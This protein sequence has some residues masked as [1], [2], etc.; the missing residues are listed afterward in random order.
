M[1]SKVMCVEMEKS[2]DIVRERDAIKQALSASVSDTASKVFVAAFYKNAYKMLSADTI[3]A[4]ISCRTLMI[5]NNNFLYNALDASNAE[6]IIKIKELKKEAMDN[7]HKL[8]TTCRKLHK[9]E[10]KLQKLTRGRKN[11]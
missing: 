5:P 7:M 11:D 2:L 4:L 10:I 9:A 1:Q 6:K 3:D 8:I